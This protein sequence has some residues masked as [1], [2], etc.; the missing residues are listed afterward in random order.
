[1]PASRKRCG[2]CSSRTTS[3]GCFSRKKPT[4]RRPSLTRVVVIGANGQLGSD[5]TAAFAAECHAVCPLS[6]QDFEILSPDSS[7]LA[8]E[9]DQPAFG[10]HA[11]P[12]Y[13]FLHCQTHTT[14]SL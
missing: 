4:P 12:Y 13:N 10:I 14:Y 5:V 11:A 2:G 1:M 7:N 6:H 8:F 3:S 9:Q